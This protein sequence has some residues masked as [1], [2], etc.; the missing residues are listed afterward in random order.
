MMRSSGCAHLRCEHFAD[1][2]VLHEPLHHVCVIVRYAVRAVQAARVCQC[3]LDQRGCVIHLAA[4][5]G[6]IDAMMKAQ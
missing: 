2:V 3:L 1:A 6:G 5:S 4:S